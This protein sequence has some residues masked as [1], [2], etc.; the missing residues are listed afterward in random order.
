MNF[1]EDTLRNKEVIKGKKLC[2]REV[3]LTIF[4]Q[5]L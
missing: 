4:L 2:S 5:E 3:I 1:E